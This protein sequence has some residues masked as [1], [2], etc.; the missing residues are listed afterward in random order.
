MTLTPHVKDFLDTLARNGHV[1]TDQQPSAVAAREESVQRRARLMI[2]APTM[3]SVDDRWIPTPDGQLKVRVYVPQQRSGVTVVWLHGGGWVVGDI[4]AAHAESARIADESGA[5][6]VSVD[7]RLAPE[8]PYPAGP[9]DCFAALGW[10]AE[11]IADLGADPDRLVVGGISSGGNL[12]ALA[13]QRALREGAPHLA[14]QVLVVP[15]MDLRGGTA[16]WERLGS[17]Y[18]L[19]Q[20]THDWYL[21]HYLGPDDRTDDPLIS[22]GLSADLAGLPPTLLITAEY[23]PLRDEGLAYLERLRAA[24][25]EVRHIDYAGVIHGF[26]GQLGPIPESESAFAEIGA[27]IRGAGADSG[28]PVESRE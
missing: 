27:A 25:V 3:D 20:A 4:E 19:T 7:Y 18:L 10:A 15:A 9:N 26:I 1:P 2:S 22:P 12:A 16:S 17:G 6:L 5:V 21:H 11:H 8:H 14:A 28:R 24:G 13:A 23:D